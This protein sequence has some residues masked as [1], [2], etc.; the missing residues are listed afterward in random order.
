M[1]EAIFCFQAELNHFLPH[2]KKGVSFVYSFKERPSVKDAIESLGVPHPEIYCI[3][4]NGQD[5]DFSYGMQDG[6]RVDVYPISAAS[7]I[8]SVIQLQPPI[9]ETPRFILDVHL[10]KLASSLRLLGFDALYRND[11]EDAQIARISAAE[12]RVVLTRDLGVLMRSLVTLGYY[13][14]D[15]K[16]QHQIIEILRRFQLGNKVKPFH[17]CIRC[18]GTLNQVDKQLIIDR[19]PQETK[20]Q[21]DRY[22]RCSNCEQIYWKGAHFQR[23][24]EFVGKAIAHSAMP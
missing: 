10:G 24:Q 18:N 20:R 5:V 17:R 2:Q 1:S 7:K 23:M 4:V 9:P 19:L 3:L 22:Y 16:P 13:V 21:I 8:N 14:R 15:T 6:D 12:S 11:Y